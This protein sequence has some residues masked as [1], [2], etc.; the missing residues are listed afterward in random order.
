MKINI[1]RLVFMDFDKTLFNTPMPEGGIEKWEEAKGK[2]FTHEDWWSR[3]ESLDLSIFNIKPFPTILNQL[4]D[5]TARRDTYTVLLSSRIEQLKSYIKRILIKNKIH[6]DSISLSKD[7]ND[8]KAK[9]IKEYLD[10]FPSVTEIA[11]Y[12]D[13]KKELTLLSEL[14][15]E[16]G[17]DITVNIYKVDNDKI[18]LTESY[19]N[20]KHII[21]GVLMEFDKENKNN[22]IYKKR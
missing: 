14:K 1:K 13:R 8:N 7:I 15:K 10:K 22:R 2:K 17:D 12:D 20:L 3:P 19:K 18:S 16:I 21:S 4:R 11:V 9:R 6:F 5:D